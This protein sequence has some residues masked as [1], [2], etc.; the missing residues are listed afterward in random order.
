MYVVTATSTVTV[1][2]AFL[3][4]IKT[5]DHELWDMLDQLR[6]LCSRPIDVSDHCRRFVD[7]LL[8]FRDQLALHFALEEAYGY[9]DEPLDVCQA[10]SREAEKLRQEHRRLHEHL[11]Q[12]VDRAESLLENGSRAQLA[13]SVPGQFI[14]FDAALLNHEERE[15]ELLMRA[16]GE[17]LGSGD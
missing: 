6:Y 10:F 15:N 11:S 14:L 17:D 2:A 9:F 16:V 4:E 7:M 1:N 3:H 8:E 12:L 5:V 13:S